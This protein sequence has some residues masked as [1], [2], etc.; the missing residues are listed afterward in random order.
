MLIPIGPTWGRYSEEWNLHFGF[1]L[2]DPRRFD[3]PVP[4]M[5]KLLKLPDDLQVE[6]LNSSHWTLE[7]LL[8]SKY[9]QGRVLLAGDACHKR[10]PTSGLG[11]NTSIDDAYSLAWKLAAVINGKAHT[12]L[13]DTY[14]ME[15]RP[16]GKA[17]R[18]WA[19]L[20]FGNRV[21]L[22]AAIGL[23]P[24]S[25]EANSQRAQQLFDGSDTGR[26]MLNHIQNI[27]DSQNI[28]FSAR[29]IELGYYYEHGAVIADGTPPP[30]FDPT[31]KLYVPTTR[32]GHR[33][34]HAW[35][36]RGRDEKVSTH[37]I[38]RFDD[39]F[40]VLT[41]E[42]GDAWVTAATKYAKDKGL[43][44]TCATIRSEQFASGAEY[45]DW[46][47]KWE[48]LREFQNGGAILLRPDN[49]V[50]WRSIHPTTR[51]GEEIAEAM[52]MLL[53]SRDLSKA[54]P[55]HTGLAQGLIHRV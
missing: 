24:N 53:W 32:P 41:D 28:E 50:G 13:L 18:D 17:T 21:V 45:L 52:E 25:T 29:N 4:A 49:F 30:A 15:R 11:L 38:L 3:D 2:D 54:I 31:G 9:R 55:M 8:A 34:P 26:Y 16:R 1:G 36:G 39:D 40:A 46:D 10:P 7:G 43:N 22:D 42:Q 44:V 37:D 48:T 33:L 5:R 19:L 20:A 35:L 47:N 6:V 51:G 14:E 23:R 12:S 27:V